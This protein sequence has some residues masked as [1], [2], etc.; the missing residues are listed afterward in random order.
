MGQMRFRLQNR[1]RIADDG[2]HRI[3]VSGAEEVPWQ[4]HA[5]WEDDQL[6]VER[7]ANE[8]GNIS[9]PWQVDG[10]G[11]CLLTTGTLMERARPY[12]LDVELA[13]G[14]IQRIRNH[15]FVWEWLEFQCPEQL[16]KDLQRATR[17]FSLAATIQEFPPEAAVA[18]NRAI[19]LALPTAEVITQHFAE[20]ALEARHKEQSQIAT[21]VG[22]SLTPEI[23]DVDI[24][25][26]LV[27]TCNI[28]EIPIAW[29]SIEANEG[30]REWKQTDQQ[31]AWCQKSG[32]KVAAGPLLRLDDLGVP[33]WMVLW[34]GDFENLA[35]VMLDHVRAVV[36]R[37]AGRV[38]L[39]HVASRVNTS[40]LLK[41]EEEQRLYL[42]AQAL[43][44]VRQIDPRT[45]TVVSFDQPWAEY[46]G[47]Q[48]EDLAPVHYADALVRA[49][50]G[51]SGF[52]LELNL[53]CRPGGSSRRPTFEIG[54]LLDQWSIWGLPLMVSLST[55]SD[56]KE[57]QQA[58]QGMQ[59]DPV[60][61]DGTA[62]P[63][64]QRNWAASVLPL[65]LCRNNV[66]VVLWNQLTD[67]AAHEFPHAG[68]FDEL[69]YPKPVVRHIRDLRKKYLI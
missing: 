65:L 45:P 68:L 59:V 1:N 43:E 52:G 23:P 27:E 41:L 44:I 15:L 42:V 38:H 53:G 3:F 11:E 63:E 58:R 16:Q 4:T 29:R 8:S 9:V 7:S 39:W 31:L 34:E 67:A 62:T 12:L 69:N 17:E 40:K 26:Q 47:Q 49:D 37:Y 25:R 20:A 66:Q 24:L 56:S 61:L 5:F 50:L 48:D 54:R 6:V 46:L 57:D 35:R 60:G 64:T 22:T 2:L 13:R 36:S 55:A 28:I 19:A 14:L 18:A 30:T 21:L 32:L 10:Y 33:A 51:I